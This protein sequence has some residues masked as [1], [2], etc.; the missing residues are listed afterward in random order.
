MTSLV[1][2]R[3]WNL[4]A[5]GTL[6]LLPM[7]RRL[8]LSIYNISLSHEL[9][10][11]LLLLKLLRKRKMAGGGGKLGLAG[12]CS[13]PLFWGSHLGCGP[14]RVLDPG[15]NISITIV[16]TFDRATPGHNSKAGGLSWASSSSLPKSFSQFGN[17]F[18]PPLSHSLA[19]PPP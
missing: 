18:I 12:R 3:G 11:L 5:E 7:K 14:C 2:E 6:G 8:L 16:A 17:I 19:N 15:G 4:W 13:P 9:L 1:D 10:S